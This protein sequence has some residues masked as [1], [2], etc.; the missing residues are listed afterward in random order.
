MDSSFFNE[1]LKSFDERRLLAYNRLNEMGFEVVKPKGAFYIMPDV[2]NFGLTGTEFSERIIKEQGVAIV[3]GNTFG[4]Y[5]ESKIR[6][7]Y[8]TEINKLE[9]AMDRI[10]RFVGKL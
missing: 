6:I 8:A 5:S 1:I 2:S 4:S 3:P 7:S 10:A 9:E